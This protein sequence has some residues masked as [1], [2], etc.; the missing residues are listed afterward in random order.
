LVGVF[1][2]N[3]NPQAGK[4]LL[5]HNGGNTNAWLELKLVG[6]ASNRSAIGAKMRAH[7]TIGGKSFWQLREFNG[8]DQYND[9]P[10]VGHFGLGDATNV[11]A[12]RI[13][14]PSGIVQTFSNVAPRQILTVVESQQTTGPA[15]AFTSASVPTNGIVNL[16]ASGPTNLLYVV[17]GSTNFV[18]WTKLGVVFNASG[19]IRFTDTHANEFASRFYRVSIP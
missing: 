6:T 8:G 17:E 12:L 16:T 2:V 9:C 4:L 18:N 3:N 19:N 1:S 11:D 5:Y 7:A 13:E 14:W 10:L 15:P